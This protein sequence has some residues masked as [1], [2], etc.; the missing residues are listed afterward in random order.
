M[1]TK[2]WFFLIIMSG[3]I[4]V[5]Q[6]NLVLI[7]YEKHLHIILSFNISSIIKP[8]STPLKDYFGKTSKNRLTFITY[9]LAFNEPS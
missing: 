4:P 1:L 5:F 9:T 2:T 7:N 8:I 3:V 6:I